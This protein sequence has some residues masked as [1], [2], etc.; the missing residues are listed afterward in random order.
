M[1]VI[2]NTDKNTLEIED[3]GV[4]L[5]TLLACGAK[6]YATSGR[7]KWSVYYHGAKIAEIQIKDTHL[8]G[9]RNEHSSSTSPDRSRNQA[10]AVEGAGVVVVEG[11][12]GP[13]G[14]VSIESTAGVGAVSSIGTGGHDYAGD[15]SKGA[16][17]K[18]ATEHQG[19]DL[20]GSR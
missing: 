4:T 19:V 17:Q 7:R 10:K 1:A 13:H 14:N 20:Q 3:I 2:V 9:K 11:P 12:P 18:H 5:R 6:G 16:D 15:A 8:K